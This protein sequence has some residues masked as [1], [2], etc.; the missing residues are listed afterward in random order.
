MPLPSLEKFL[1]SPMTN[2]YVRYKNLE[3]YVRKSRRCIDGVMVLALDRANTK[4]K[5]RSG[6]IGKKL[7]YIRTG[8]YR[9]FDHHMGEL[10]KSYGYDGI[11][12]ENVINEFLLDKL[13]DMGYRIVDPD[14]SSSCFWKGIR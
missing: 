7:K 5:K 13:P 10:A 9:E 1:Q 4:N 11:Y 6:N 14:Y 12:V 8:L 3:S 2:S